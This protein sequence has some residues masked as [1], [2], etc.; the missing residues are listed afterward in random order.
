MEDKTLNT[1]EQLDYNPILGS[2]QEKSF[3]W[4]DFLGRFEWTWFCTLTFRESVHPEKAEKL[5]HVW[6][7]MMNAR[8]YGR[9]WYKKKDRCVRWVR[10]IEMQ[11]RNVL[12][13][14]A[15]IGGKGTPKL[16][17]REFEEA[18]FKLAGIARMS[19]VEAQGAV[20]AYVSKYVS[21]GGRI[22]MGGPLDDLDQLGQDD[23][24]SFSSEAVGLTS[25][26]A[27][28]RAAADVVKLLIPSSRARPLGSV[29]VSAIDRRKTSWPKPKPEPDLVMDWKTGKMV[30]GVPEDEPLYRVDRPGPLPGRCS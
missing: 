18:W 9:R 29:G 6:W 14:H 10:A 8:L 17:A 20:L 15:L 12:H 23:Q 22:D 2:C 28:G 25:P 26:E 7:C 11:K 27:Q 3:A 4:A 5:F 24:V 13:Y 1:T 21:K 16:K 19:P 30:P